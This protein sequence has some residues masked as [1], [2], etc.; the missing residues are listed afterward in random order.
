MENDI[1]EEE[2]T[3]DLIS[4]VDTSKKPCTIVF[5]GQ[6]DSGKSTITTSILKNCQLLDERLVAQQEINKLNNKIAF[7]FTDIFF[8]EE[9]EHGKT[10]EFSKSF[11]STENK[12]FTLLDC[13]GHERFVP[14]MLIGACNADYAGIILSAKPGEY[15]SGISEKGATK[16]HTILAKSLGVHKLI[17]LVN[18]MD[19][20]K[21]DESRYIDIKNDFSKFI[22]TVGFNLDTDVFWIPVS[23]ITS[24]NLFENENIVKKCKW[25]KGDNLKELLNKIDVPPRKETEDKIRISVS[26]R[27]KENSLNIMGKLE[28]G[29]IKTG[30]NYIVIPSMQEF[31]I[32]KIYNSEEMLV[33]F[34]Y[35]GEWIRIQTKSVIDVSRGDIICNIEDC[36]PSFNTFIADILLLEGILSKGS[37]CMLH[38]HTLS[39]G[40]TIEDIMEMNKI[41]KTEKNVNFIRNHSRAKLVIK[42]DSLVSGEKFEVLSGL[43]RITLRLDQST[44]A[45][46]KILKYKPHK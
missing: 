39:V 5:I 24:E 14:N 34:A 44:I 13:P 46:G 27:Y 32:Q 15:E 42:C 20:A 18:K 26:D 21:W 3:N 8:E 23:G 22:K 12:R 40:V 2:D 45:I 6:V 28:C 43:G 30:K 7:N 25:Y 29:I 9:Q 11:F 41:N 36:A 19:E 38:L 4:E 31:E 1:Y 10:F 16:E 33:P 17:C 37:R 35:A